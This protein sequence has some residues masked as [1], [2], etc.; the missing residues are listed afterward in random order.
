MNSTSNTSAQQVATYKPS[1][2]TGMLGPVI[3]FLCT[4][5]GGAILGV[6]YSYI[7]TWIPFIYINFFITIGFAFGLAFLIRTGSLLGHV[8]SGIVNLVFGGLGLITAYYV[9]WVAWIAAQNIGIGWVWDP[10]ALFGI[11][12]EINEH[13]LW[14]IGRFGSDGAIVSGVF[15]TIIWVIEALIIFLGGM[16]GMTVDS[17]YCERCR[18]WTSTNDDLSRMDLKGADVLL[19]GLHQGEF[20]VFSQLQPA[21]ENAIEYLKLDTC[22]CEG[23]SDFAVLSMSHVFIEYDEEGKENNRETPIMSKAIVPY[24]VVT[25]LVSRFS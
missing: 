2:K 20:D 17:V 22:W 3:T 4:A 18:K 10:L 12:K 21:A 5:I 16:M 7:V 1:G 8:R 15:L 24:P 23:C 13:G 19:D 11:I 9:H 14:S 25:D 6:L